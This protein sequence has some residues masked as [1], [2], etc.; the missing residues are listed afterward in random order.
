MDDME[1]DI[2]QVEGAKKVMSG[3]IEIVGDN[4]PLAFG[5]L[6]LLGLMSPRIRRA[7]RKILGRRNK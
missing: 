7:A 2:K 3:L 5:V 4:L 1:Q 6:A